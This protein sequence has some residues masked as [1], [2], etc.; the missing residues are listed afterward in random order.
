[1]GN[2]KRIERTSQAEECRGVYAVYLN[3][4]CAYIGAATNVRNRIRGHDALRMIREI[5]TPYFKYRKVDQD[6]DLWATEIR[7]IKKL[8]PEFNRLHN[9]IA[10]SKED[11]EAQQ[12]ICRGVRDLRLCLGETQMTFS[13]RVGVHPV[14]VARYETGREPKG[15][16]LATLE[17][18]AKQK[19]QPELATIFKDALYGVKRTNGRRRK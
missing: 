17:Q 7:L 16:V 11:E 4:K 19:R 1:M 13:K 6:A 12:L 9:K 2:W 8:R 18:L 5:D 14:T 10:A 15:T 3:G